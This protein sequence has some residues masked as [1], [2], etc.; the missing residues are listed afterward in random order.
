METQAPV[1]VAASLRRAAAL[2]IDEALR[3]VGDAVRRP[4]LVTVSKEEVAMAKA[5]LEPR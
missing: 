3:V 2:Q 4:W 1:W 5:W